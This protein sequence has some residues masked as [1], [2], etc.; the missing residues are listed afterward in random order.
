MHDTDAD[1]LVMTTREGDTVGFPVSSA[2]MIVY[3]QEKPITKQ[4]P[5]AT[6]QPDPA[7]TEAPADHQLAT[8][9]ATPDHQ[10]VTKPKAKPRKP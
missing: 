5:P 1:M 10:P 8:K 3:E 9:P 4:A 7:T 2:V 6:K